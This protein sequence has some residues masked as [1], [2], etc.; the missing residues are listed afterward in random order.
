[1]ERKSDAEA[2]YD[3]FENFL[4]QAQHRWHSRGKSGFSINVF[5]YI[6]QPDSAATTLLTFGLSS[7]QLRTREVTPVAVRTELMICANA[8]FHSKALSALL[9]AV[10]FDALDEHLIPAEHRVLSGSGPV[11]T[12]GHARFEHL[13]FARPGFFPLN[14]QRFE[15]VSLPVDVM[16]IIPISTS[17]KELISIE[18]WES[19]EDLVIAQ[20]IDLLDFDRRDEVV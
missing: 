3:H 16:Q 15:E 11:L 14:F 18:G 17:E 9:F 10:A 5:E 7:H 20:G 13:Y 2:L 8:E 12:G 19:F 6:G 1:M 4:G